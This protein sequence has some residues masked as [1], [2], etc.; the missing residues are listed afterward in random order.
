M[1]IVQETVEEKKSTRRV[2][3]ANRGRLLL[4]TPGPVPIWDLQVF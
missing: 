3:H 1:Y 4:W 2:R